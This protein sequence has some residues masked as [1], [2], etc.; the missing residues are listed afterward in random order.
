M[1]F[2]QLLVHLTIAYHRS[3]VPRLERA[4]KAAGV[5]YRWQ[6]D[7]TGIQ[8][9]RIGAGLAYIIDIKHV[10]NFSY[11]LGITNTGPRWTYQGIPFIQLVININKE[12][13]Y[14]PAKYINF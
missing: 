4:E 5:F 7:F 9:V 14:L 11:F 12:Y 6:N 3:M 10:L 1:Q 8:F 2:T 13:K